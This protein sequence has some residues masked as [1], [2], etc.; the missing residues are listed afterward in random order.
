MTDARPGSS[1]ERPLEVDFVLSAFSKFGRAVR[2]AVG[3]DGPLAAIMRRSNRPV[4]A[5]PISHVPD[6]AA[7]IDRARSLRITLNL[8]TYGVFRMPLFPSR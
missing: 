7:G 2:A 5:G 1:G 3:R 6:K 8:I 4:R